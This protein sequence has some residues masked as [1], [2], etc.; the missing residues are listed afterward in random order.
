[1]FLSFQRTVSVLFFLCFSISIFAQNASF[2]LSPK[3]QKGASH[4][5]ELTKGKQI[6]QNNK[7][8]IENESRQIV[9]M[10][11]VEAT[12]KGYIMSARYENTLN[13]PDP[14]DVRYTIGQNGDFQ[15]IINIRE[16]Q[17]SFYTLFDNL[18]AV[19]ASNPSVAKS[20]GEMRQFMTSDNYITNNVFQELVLIHQFYNNR[21]TVDSLERYQTQLPN[22]FNPTGKPIIANATL[23]A[24]REGGFAFIKHTVEPDINAIKQQ[25]AQYINHINSSNS[26]KLAVHDTPLSSLNEAILEEKIFDED[27]CSFDLTTG[28]IAAFQRKRTI[29]EGDVKTVE[30]VFL[31]EMR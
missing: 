3:W 20:V 4:R 28:W 16:V 2:F 27:F 14:I 5:F 9:T 6:F 18:T 24:K 21:F 15:G 22:L 25:A 26:S 11:V 7:E 29:L 17:R 12:A 19:A 31:K 8:S 23:L 1:M 13:S 10:S 30:F